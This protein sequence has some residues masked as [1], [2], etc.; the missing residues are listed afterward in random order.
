MNNPFISL[1]F[2]N[3]LWRPFVAHFVF[4][5]K[6]PKSSTLPAEENSTLRVL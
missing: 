3:I 2:I 1:M 6:I 4:Q 5:K